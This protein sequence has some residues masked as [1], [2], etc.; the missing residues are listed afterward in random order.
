MSGMKVLLG[1]PKLHGTLLRSD[2]CK[3]SPRYRALIC[4]CLNHFTLAAVSK[5]MYL[6]DMWKWEWGASF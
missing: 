5:A 2:N 1:F 3:L 4:A 6:H